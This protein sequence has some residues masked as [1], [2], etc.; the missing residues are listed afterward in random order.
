MDLIIVYFSNS[1][2]SISGNEKQETNIMSA[3][4]HNNDV[5]KYKVC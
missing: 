3:D 5:S 2:F 4:D 1:H